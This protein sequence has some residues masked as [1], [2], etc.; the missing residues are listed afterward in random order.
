VDGNRNGLGLG[1]YIAREIVA[2]HG[3][4]MWWRATRDV[5]APFV[6]AAA[7][8]AGQTSR[9]RNHT[10]WASA[11]RHC[12]GAGGTDAAFEG[13]ARKL[14]R[15]CDRSLECVRRCIYVDKDLVL[16]PMETDGATETLYVVAQPIWS[17]SRS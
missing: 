16:P 9:S 5:A 2:R 15:I 1:L 10:P 6:H 17:E 4:R 11:K 3:G 12:A 13:V 7:V 8:F 14:E